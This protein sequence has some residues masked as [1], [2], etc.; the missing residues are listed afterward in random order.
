MEITFI[1]FQGQNL[2]KRSKSNV[3]LLDET[4]FINNFGPDDVGD[5][6]C[7]VTNQAGTQASN[8]LHLGVKGKMFSDFYEL[9]CILYISIFNK[10]ATAVE[11]QGVLFIVLEGNT[12]YFL[13]DL[14]KKIFFKE[15][16]STKIYYFKQGCF[17]N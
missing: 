12:N 3:H 16:L 7:I 13:D 9:Y 6:K 11:R 1:P 17:D 4:L 10:I 14:D 8:V 15:F 5:Y 2:E